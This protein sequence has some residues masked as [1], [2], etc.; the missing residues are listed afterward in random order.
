MKKSHMFVTKI[1]IFSIVC[2]GFLSFGFQVVRPKTGI[3][4]YK[5]VTTFYKQPKNSIDVIFI[6]ASSFHHG[7]SPLAI[8]EEEGI[9]SYSRATSVQAPAVSYYYLMET[10]KYQHPKVVVLDGVS[11]FR[12]YDVDEDEGWLRQA[13]DP[14]R[15]SIEKIR[16]ILEIVAKSNIQTIDSYLFPFLRYHSRWN[17]LRT[18]DFDFMQIDTYDHFKGMVVDIRINPREMP[19]NYMVEE[20]EAAQFDEDALFYFERIIELCKKNNIDVLFLTLPRLQWNYSK[21]LGVEQLAKKHGLN[22]V[23]YSSPV[24]FEKIGL[25]LSRDFYDDNHLNVYGAQK[26]SKDLS[27]FLK[28]TYTLPDRRNDSKYTQ[29]NFDLAYYKERLEQ[30]EAQVQAP[31][32]N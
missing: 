6:G 17:D 24:Y 30:A 18:A 28:E 7:I 9:V 31:E 19:E 32:E 12:Y 14:M 22:Y 25:D 10:M 3:G 29:W 8:W 21:H 11:L 13:I 20:G 2:F 4:T 15:F 16:L 1:I 23:D 5:R 27:S 26:L